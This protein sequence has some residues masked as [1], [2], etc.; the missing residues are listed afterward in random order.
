MDAQAWQELLDHLACGVVLFDAEDRL[1]LCNADFRRLYPALAGELEPGIRF[2]DIVR[3][4]V[5]RGLVPEAAGREEPWIAERLREHAE[6]AGAIVRRM[7][8]GRWRRIVEMRLADGSLLAFSFD[9]TDQV[10]KAEQA[11][12]ALAQARLAS[13]RLDDAIAALPAGF[14]LWDADERLV[15]C[16]AELAHLYPAIADLLQPGASWEALVRANH[17]RGGLPVPAAELDAYIARRR[18]E[19]RAAQ[20]PTTQ[21]TADGRWI[22]TIER[23]TRDG[24]LVAVRVDITEQRA[25][26]AAAEA[27]T[28]RLHEAIEALPD[29]FALYDADD[30]LVVCNARYREIY[31]ASAAAMTTGMRFEDMLRYGLAQGQYPQAAGRE[32]EWLA[33][34][35]HLHRNPGSPHLQQLPGNRWL[36]IDERRTRDGG[37]AGVRT[38]VTELVRREQQLVE[39]NA[40]LDAA[41]ARLEEVSETDALTGIANRRHFDRRLTEEW[42]RLARHGT[43]FALLLADVDHFKRYNDRHGHLSGDRCLR[44]VAQALLACA[45]RPTDLV[46]RYGGEE[47]V[48]LLPH[49]TPDAAAT[50][51]LR[52]LGVVDDLRLPHGDSPVAPFVTLSIGGACARPGHPEGPEA[53]LQAADRALYRAKAAGR[54]RV[55]FDGSET[56]GGGGIG[57]AGRPGLAGRA[58]RKRPAA[59]Q[60]RTVHWTVRVRARP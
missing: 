53:L 15:T 26:R 43:P 4:A 3:R 27:A 7:P 9:I 59:R 55:E 33:E 13:E 32:A 19:R 20:Q 34:R 25:Q 60:A 11:E 50:Q 45:R 22:R 42:S 56:A 48:V 58:G 18:A 12:R 1:V 36:R 28:A 38:E 49:T 51:A 5:A 29:G 35:L 24:G 10:V 47:F 16:N 17:A 39:L 30:R 52:L 31:A 8:D 54:H 2:E 44:R 41:R 21:T 6:P 40:Q 14:E 46:A 37:I 23:P 57:P